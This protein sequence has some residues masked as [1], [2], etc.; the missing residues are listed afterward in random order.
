MLGCV[1]V[2]GGLP[3]WGWF[4]SSLGIVARISDAAVQIKLRRFAGS[5][6]KHW[7]EPVG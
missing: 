7:L 2:Y 5:L 1:V 6:S 4:N 3:I